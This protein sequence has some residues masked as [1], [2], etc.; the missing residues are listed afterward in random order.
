VKTIKVLTG[1]IL[2]VL[3]VMSMTGCG[4][5]PRLFEIPEDPNYLWASK[6]ATSRTAE[7]AL[8]KATETARLELVSQMQI[9]IEGMFKRFYEEIGVGEDAEMLD[10]AQRV[11]RSVVSEV[12]KD[13]RVVRQDYVKEGMS[14]RAFVLATVSSGQ[15]YEELDKKLQE[16]EQTYTR[17]KA[18][19]AFKDLEQEIERYEKFKKE[20]GL[21][22]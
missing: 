7:V 1:M 2:S 17:F 13:S 8:D 18:T 10:Y 11:S 6:T 12:L 15:M 20:Q 3:F 5:S 22:R 4:K 16:K 9:K 21:M 19:E 14:Y